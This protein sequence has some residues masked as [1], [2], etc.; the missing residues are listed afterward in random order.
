MTLGGQDVQAALFHH[1][2][3]QDDVGAAAGHVGGNGDMAEL[4]GLGHDLRFLFVV[5]GVQ[6]LVLDAFP[7]EELAQVLGFLDGGGAHQHRLAAIMA[8]LNLLHRGQEFLRPGP[9]D[10]VGIIDADHFLVGGDDGYVQFVDLFKLLRLGVGGAGHACQFVV[11]AEIILEGDGGQGLVFILDAHPF[12]GLQGL[13]QAVGI[14]PA[15]HEAAGEFVHDDDLA[16]L[17]DVF[18]I[19]LEELVGFQGLVQV[20]QDLDVARVIEV[21]DVQELFGVGDA[22]FGDEDASRLFIHREILLLLQAAGPPGSG[23]S[24]GWW[25]PQPG[26]R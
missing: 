12:L 21:L 16:F 23:C 20:M 4:P 6:H 24:R 17:D 8:F 2:L 10:E 25:I 26:R 9:V 1:P 3:A 15:R 7:F 14:A 22:A 5:L 19:P 18:L 11:H 13:V